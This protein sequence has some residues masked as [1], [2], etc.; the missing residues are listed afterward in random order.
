MLV[1]P[2]FLVAAWIL[3]I[4]YLVKLESLFSPSAGLRPQIKL[5]RNARMAGI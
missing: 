3:G 4:Y 5:L 2:S 1:H